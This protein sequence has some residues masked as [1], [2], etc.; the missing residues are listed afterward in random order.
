M[1]D[2][3]HLIVRLTA[4]PSAEPATD[5]AKALLFQSVRELLSNAVKHAG[6]PHATVE[7]TRQAAHLQIVV[8]DHG[9]GFAPDRIQAAAAHGLGLATIRQ[10]PRPGQP[11][12][13]AHPAGAR[14]ARARCAICRTR[15]HGT[16]AEN[17]RT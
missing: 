14:V 10:C 2:T 17:L 4:D 1:Q 7:V 8:A 6:V 5:A 15:T 12:H 13:P 9:H 3:H 11:V 16:L